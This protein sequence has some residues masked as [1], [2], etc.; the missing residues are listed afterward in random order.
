MLDLE[1]AVVDLIPRRGTSAGSNILP[2]TMARSVCS[3]SISIVSRSVSSVL[4]SMSTSS[5]LSVSASA[6]DWLWFCGEPNSEVPLIRLWPVTTTTASIVLC[7]FGGRPTDIL[8]T[9]AS[10]RC[11]T[12]F[13][14]V[15]ELSEPV[16]DCLCDRGR[17]SGRGCSYRSFSYTSSSRG[18]TKLSMYMSDMRRREGSSMS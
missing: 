8:T 6:S 17:S 14:L 2:G 16:R 15:L 11:L 1:L 13:P 9:G 5:L 12:L 10:F 3:S 7:F 4:S 18:E